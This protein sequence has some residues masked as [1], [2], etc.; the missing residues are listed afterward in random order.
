MSGFEVVG[1]ILGLYPIIASTLQVY[2]NAA[3]ETRAMSFEREIM[4][5]EIISND[6]RL[7]LADLASPEASHNSNNV[8]EDGFWDNLELQNRLFQSLGTQKT[9]LLLSLLKEIEQILTEIRTQISN[10]KNLT[11]PLN[12]SIFPQNCIL[13]TFRNE[14]EAGFREQ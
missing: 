9:H 3:F 14:P 12:P 13:T 8:L 10:T 7:E 4:I 2:H 5:E 6:H 11:V 1:V